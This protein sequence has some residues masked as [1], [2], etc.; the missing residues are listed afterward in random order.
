MNIKE[1]QCPYPNSGLNRGEVRVKIRTS[2]LDVPTPAAC[3]N[4][5]LEYMLHT[6]T[7]QTLNGIQGI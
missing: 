2:L 5:V 1:K 3:K 6:H 4:D 7:Q